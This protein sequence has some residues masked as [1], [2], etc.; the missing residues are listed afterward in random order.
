MYGYEAHEFVWVRI[1]NTTYVAR[2]FNNM[3]IPQRGYEN[4]E[5]LHFSST[6][7]H[8]TPFPLVHWIISHKWSAFFFPNDCLIVRLFSLFPSLQISSHHHENLKKTRLMGCLRCLLQ[9]FYFFS[10]FKA[11]HLID[12]VYVG[13]LRKQVFTGKKRYSSSG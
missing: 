8:P 13:E 6:F 2:R 1:I 4:Q 7:I 10:T 11:G 5:A 12:F 9:P 3:F